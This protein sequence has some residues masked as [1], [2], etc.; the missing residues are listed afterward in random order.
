MLLNLV[1]ER[2]ETPQVPPIFSK[3]A[4]AAHT[5]NFEH[6]DERHLKHAPHRL[7]DND[8]FSYDIAA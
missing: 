1:G 6:F 4:Y 7:I 3:K 2:L 8:L 5:A